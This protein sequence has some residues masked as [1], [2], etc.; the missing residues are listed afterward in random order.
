MSSSFIPP[1]RRALKS[2]RLILSITAIV[3]IL[4]LALAFGT[5]VTKRLWSDEAWFASPAFNL[6]TEGTMGTDV[7]ETSGTKLA[8]MKRYTYWIMP[9]Y[10]VTQAAWYK[11]VGFGVWQLRFSAALWGLV[12]LAAWYV[13]MCRL[14][15]DPTIA[16]L[17]CTLLA[18]DYVFIMAASNGRMD[19]MCAALGFAG[20]AAYLY[21]RETHFNLAVF[22]GHALVVAS[23]MTHFLGALQLVI[24]LFVTLRFDARRLRPSHFA[25]AAITYFIAAAAWGWYISHDPVSFIN[26][27]TANATT[28]NR[29][30]GF[31]AP[32]NA[33]K[34]E[35]FDRYFQS[36]GWGTHS[37]GHSGV[38]RFKILILGS[39]VIALA[40]AL[41]V[42]DVRRGRGVKPLL[43]LTSIV[44]LIMMVLD[45]QKLSFY[46]IH[47]VPFYTALLTVWTV[48]CWRHRWQSGILPH[49]VSRTIIATCIAGL[50][51]LQIG[52]TLYRMRINAHGKDFLPAAA[53]LKHHAKANDIII[54][55]AELG[56]ELGFTDNLVDDV[57]LGY[58]TGKHPAYVVIE[59]TYQRSLD[60]YRT[61]EPEL[62]AYVTKLLTEELRLVYDRNHYKI[63]ARQEN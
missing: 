16:R 51:T 20:F 43:A 21:W 56:F 17:T 36:F 10:V 12:A 24:L 31:T 61:S 54:G 35:I 57:R 60:A 18:L 13:I 62:D 49:I 1:V 14:T 28:A 37:A 44:F 11:L 48:W 3:A 41:L 40:G 42:A 34:S 7:L 59:E 29:M 39:Y 25:L 50:L 22:V 46:L 45:G 23:G 55:S 26:Q 53:Y 33:L 6:A 5:G 47:I 38:V 63:Y 30:G 27:F 52:G 8:G 2:R 32:L 15:D 19:M 4:Y 9:L 58:T